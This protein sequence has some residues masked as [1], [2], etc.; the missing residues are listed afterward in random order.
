MSTLLTPGQVCE[1]YGISIHTLYMWTSKNLIP[2]LKIRG[3]N[4]F[5][6]E[7]LKKWEESKLVT[8]AETK[9]L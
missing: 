1:R 6:E 2:R 4:R 3:F 9:L 8:A 7:D 5:R